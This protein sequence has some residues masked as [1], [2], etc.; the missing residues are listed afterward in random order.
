MTYISNVSNDV[1]NNMRA[2]Q[3]SEFNAQ[4]EGYANRTTET[5]YKNIT[6]AISLQEFATIYNLAT[7]WNIN[8]DS[9]KIEIRCQGTEGFSKFDSGMPEATRKTIEEFLSDLDRSGEITRYYVIFNIPQ[10]GYTNENG[11]IS[12]LNFSLRF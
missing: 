9:D 2:R 5:G 11:R 4:F 12:K 3:I 8:N 7:E 6:N 10:D 1:N